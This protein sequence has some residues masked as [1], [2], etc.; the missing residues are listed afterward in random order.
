MLAEYVMAEKDIIAKKIQ[1]LLVGIKDGDTRK[2]PEKKSSTP[3]RS[4]RPKGTRKSE[5][6]GVKHVTARVRQPELKK[7][8]DL[9]KVANIRTKPVADSPSN[10]TRGAKRKAA[11]PSDFERPY[12]RRKLQL[13]PDEEDESTEKTS[14]E[15]LGSSLDTKA[16]FDSE[17][18]TEHS[19]PPYKQGDNTPELEKVGKKFGRRIVEEEP[20]SS[21]DGKATP[22]LNPLLGALED[23]GELQR[24]EHMTEGT[25]YLEDSEPTEV[26][27]KKS[28]P[29][30]FIPRKQPV[31][32]AA[33]K[34]GVPQLTTVAT[35][36][37]EEQTWQDE[38]Q[39]DTVMEE[40]Q[41]ETE[42]TIWESVKELPSRIQKNTKD[43]R[44]ST[45]METL[46]PNQS[47][48]APAA[49]V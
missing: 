16:S 49:S 13:Q 48:L 32:R 19:T 43:M 30:P 6:A 3:N 15:T 45:T 11:V 18:G 38:A 42:Q 12:R 37:L 17:D 8:S 40:G 24:V 7:A 31:Q 44:I 39:L 28:A 5:P 46:Y 10:R 26:V 36:E 2:T 4:K 41:I 34:L 22:D 33:S 1:G 9:L 23:V 20:K 27:V 35:K 21:A 29:S 25:E 14:G 47:R